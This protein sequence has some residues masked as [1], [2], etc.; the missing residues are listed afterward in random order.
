MPVNRYQY[1]VVH[2]KTSYKVVPHVRVYFL[3]KK[4]VPPLVFSGFCSGCKYD[5]DSL[6][7]VQI[8]I[9]GGSLWC[10]GAWTAGKCRGTSRRLGRHFFAHN[11]RR[12][13]LK[14]LTVHCEQ[15]AQRAFGNHMA[16]SPL[17]WHL[18]SDAF[19]LCISGSLPEHCPSLLLSDR[20]QHNCPLFSETFPDSP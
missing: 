10:T 14:A 15:G 1:R 20:T 13:A 5:C 6:P 19:V 3:T 7:S 8:C 9:L 2:F 4:M 17:L 11:F 12:L 18:V 16:S